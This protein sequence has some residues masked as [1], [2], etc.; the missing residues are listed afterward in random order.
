MT[1][2]NLTSPMNPEHLNDTVIG[3]DALA[4]AGLATALEPA[5]LGPAAGGE[6]PGRL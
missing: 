4:P 2:A 3:I 5:L 6:P 1:L